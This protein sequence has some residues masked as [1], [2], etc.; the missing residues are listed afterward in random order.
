MKRI[1]LS[2]IIFSALFLFLS[3]TGCAKLRDEDY[4]IKSVEILYPNAKFI[5][6][7]SNTTYDDLDSKTYYFNNGDF[8]FSFCDYIQEGS[9]GFDH[10]AVTCDYYDK[11]YEFKKDEIDNVLKNSKVPAICEKDNLYTDEN[12][13]YEI[14]E[15]EKENP[16]RCVFRTPTSVSY[17]D[18]FHFEF[19]INDYAQIEM[20]TEFLTNLYDVVEKYIPTTSEK[21]CETFYID[22]NTSEYYPTPENEYYEE[23]NDIYNQ[24]KKL[25]KE[26]FDI[27][28]IKLWTKYRYAVLVKDGKLTDS[29]IDTNKVKH[30]FLDNLII[31]GK[32]IESDKYDTEF[33]YDVKNDKYYTVVSFGME[34]E[35]NGGVKDYLQREIIEE[36]Y[37]DTNYKINNSKDETTYKI[38]KNKYKVNWTTKFGESIEDDDYMI[39]Y[40]NGKDMKIKN[41]YNIGNC[42]TG[43]SYNR[44]ISIDDFA[45]IMEMEVERIDQNTKTVYLKTK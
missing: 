7:E 3:L 33:V 38:G 8:E 22:F 28:N 26:D 10:N 18:S 25:S 31:D 19:Y 1:R 40:K 44:Y 6:V 17:S 36:F 39:F 11:L 20:C 9:G 32:T 5:R 14:E 42:F 4:I 43:A 30:L 2:V 35:Y 24:N 23:R 45:K 29:K 16:F 21:F 41:F 37:N 34:F 15:F 27:D 12:N 13:D